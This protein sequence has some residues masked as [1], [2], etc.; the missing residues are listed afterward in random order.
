MKKF[1]IRS[2]MAFSVI[3]II[4]FSITMFLENR[5]KEEI[6]SDVSVKYEVLNEEISVPKMPEK[7]KANLTFSKTYF[8]SGLIISLISPVLFYIF[9]GVEII[10][11][12]SF[13]NKFFEG[14]SFC[15]LYG[16]FT[17]VMIFP[18]I[19]FSSFYRLR[20]VGLSSQSFLGFFANYMEGN[21]ESILFELPVAAFIYML[22]MKRK[23]WYIWTSTI[24]IAVVLIDNYVY[25]YVDEFRNELVD[26]EDG[27]LKSKLL[28][29]ASESGIENLDIK[30]IPK[31]YKTSS[32]NAYMTGIHNSRRI[33]FWD[34]TLNQLSEKEILSV[35][36]HE[37][38]HYKLNHIRNSMLLGMAGI[39]I[40]VLILQGILVKMKHKNYKTIE[41]VV[42]ILIM[43]N[44]VSLVFTPI[45]TAYSRKIETEADNFAMEV[46]KD[47]ITNGLL[48][49]RFV[50]SNL[51]PVDVNGFYKYMCYDHP[52]VKDRIENSNE[53]AKKL[54][55]EN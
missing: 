36:A 35:A 6:N 22:F 45:E 24:L 48:E 23:E 38:G 3:F 14:V 2:F 31:A 8:Y 26:M 16:V 46:T 34:T 40:G 27:E 9:G 39:I 41:S 33:V 55:E 4:L 17:E 10:K 25:P 32:M 44:I 11:K 20:L 1:L 53:F 43:F 29:L 19:L 12:K 18:K 54:A 50:E 49:I 47:P 42:V 52:T 28:N 5:N 13:K 37:M 7:V 21:L 30:V 15:F 51:T